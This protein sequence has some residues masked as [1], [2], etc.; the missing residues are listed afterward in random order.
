MHATF[1][2]PIRLGEATTRWRESDLLAWEGLTEIPPE[3][4]KVYL[5]DLEVADRYGVSRATIWRWS[6]KSA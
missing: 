3:A 1:P 2:Q 5:R 4:F 6:R